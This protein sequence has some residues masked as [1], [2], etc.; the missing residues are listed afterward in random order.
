[1]NAGRMILVT[2]A[3]G[4]LGSHLVHRLLASG[5]PVRGTLRDPAQGAR[6]RAALARDGVNTDGLTFVAADLTRATDWVDALAG[7]SAVIHA[8]SPFP[9]RA[10][11]NPDEVIRPAVAGTES[12][13]RAAARAGVRRAIVTSSIAAVCYG[14]AKPAGH[15]FTEDDWTD[16]NA[17]GLTAYIRS[18]ALAERA[19]W[20][21]AERE[22]LDLRIICPGL[23]LGPL[24]LP[25][26]AASVELVRRLLSGLLPGSPRLGWPVADVRDVADAHVRALGV[27]STDA[28]RFLVA[29]RFLWT[30]EIAAV[31]RAALPEVARRIP[32]RELP[33]WAVRL[34]AVADRDVRAVLFE[35]GRRRDVSCARAERHLG[36]RPRPVEE[37]LVAC[38]RSLLSAAQ[39]S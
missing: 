16:T 2:G 39:R 13:L 3:T 5:R 27:E 15:V 33:D 12:V 37:T 4:Y 19:A 9:L 24:L 26:G 20:A 6:L 28:R 36:W 31:L 29:D 7:C 21:V 17:P 18:K 25:G 1:M 32:K 38:A 30:A 8:A 14:T 22:G 35:L 10:P 23:I 34:V 11:K